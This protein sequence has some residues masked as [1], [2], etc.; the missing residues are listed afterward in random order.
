MCDL[1]KSGAWRYAEDP[2]T[3]VLTLRWVYS[4]NNSVG[5]WHPGMPFPKEFHDALNQG[6]IFTAHNAAFEKAIWRKHMMPVYGWPDIPNHQ[7]DCTLARCANLC[8]PQD[9]D[10]AVRVLRLPALKDSEASKAVIGLSKVDRKGYMPTITPEIIAAA[11]E[12]CADDCRAQKGLRERV[13][14]LSQAERQVWLLDQRINERG[15]RLDLD[16][17]DKM[18]KIVD[19][20]TVPSLKEFEQITGIPKLGSPR[21]KDWCHARGVPI[22]NLQKETIAEWLKEDDDAEDYEELAGETEGEVRGEMPEEVRRALHIKRLIGSASIKKLASARHCVS[23][24]GRARGLL[25]YHGAGPGLWAGRLLQPQNFPRGTIAAEK[26]EDAGDFATRKVEALQTGDW[27]YVETVVGPAVETVVSS[28]RH[29]VVP[30]VGREL[31]VGDFAGIQAR[32]ALAAAGQRDKIALMAGG[33]DVYIDMACDIFKMPKFD[34]RDKKLKDAFKAQYAERRQYGKNSVLGLGF[35]MG[36]KKFLARYGAGQPF[37]FAQG[38]VDTYR[39]EWAPKVPELWRGLEDA[40]RDAVWYR[41]PQEA[42]GVLYKLEDVWLTARLP[43]GRKLYY[44]NPQPIRKEMAWSTEE[45]PDVRRT[46]THQAKKRGKWLTVD[47]F[48]GL[49][50]ENLASAL[51]RDLLVAAMFKCEK[52]GLPIV[53]TVHDEIVADAEK[54]VDNAKVLKQIMEDIPQWA[55]D[56]EIPVEAETWQGD[57]YRK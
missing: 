56:M 10:T 21:L 27:Q 57:R 3:E 12:Y 34:T 15:V 36:A 24:D 41:Q 6:A 35:Q 4:F 42:Y 53:L 13:G 1:K 16:L 23:T 32:I 47:V 11:D 40:A 28:L 31:V 55:R 7:W 25:Q 2:T 54:R 20:A 37:D 22:P 9:L 5:L 18:Q 8:I 33:H 39:K 52:S 17:I 30:S 49:L 51:A 14:T 43:S 38:V 44:F 45:K 48:G 46:W 26:K 29:V 19:E 50:T